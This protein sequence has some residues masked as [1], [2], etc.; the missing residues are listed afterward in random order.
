V[1]SKFDFDS[2]TLGEVSFLEK[3]SGLGLGE[4]SND[5][6]PRGDLLIAMV[7]IVKRRTGSPQFTTVDA[8]QLTL[9]EANAIIGS[10]EDEDPAAGE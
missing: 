6:A 10:A 1:S 9:T 4:I 5:D 7:T 8:S 2:L 3:T